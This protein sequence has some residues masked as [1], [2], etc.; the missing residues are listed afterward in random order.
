MGPLAR[1]DTFPAILRPP[2]QLQ[3]LSH[4]T[5]KKNEEGRKR[6]PSDP[7]LT[8]VLLRPSDLLLDLR[9]FLQDPHSCCFGRDPRYLQLTALGTQ[10]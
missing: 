8:L 10:V 9:D 4:F 5:D 7:A 3:L 1:L 6:D 2:K